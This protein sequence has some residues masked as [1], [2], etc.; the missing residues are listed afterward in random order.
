MAL[1]H[2][3]KIYTEENFCSLSISSAE[4]NKKE[5]H[6]EQFLYSVPEY[7]AF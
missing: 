6:G 3:K 2:I 5:T 7:T 4:Y 1:K